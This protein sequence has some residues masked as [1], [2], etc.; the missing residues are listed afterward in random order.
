MG[1]SYTYTDTHKYPKKYPI[2]LGSQRLAEDIFEDLYPKIWGLMNSNKYFRK[3]KRHGVLYAKESAQHTFC[4]YLG[5][6]VG[7][8]DFFFGSHLR[9][10]IATS[11]L[12]KYLYNEGPIKHY[13]ISNYRITPYIFVR[14]R[15]SSP[16]NGRNSW[17]EQ[18][19]YPV[20]QTMGFRNRESEVD[21][22]SH[23][24]MPR[25]NSLVEH[26]I[27]VAPFYHRGKIL[28]FSVAIRGEK[29]Y[30][31]LNVD[32]FDIK[33]YYFLKYAREIRYLMCS[34]GTSSEGKRVL[35]GY[36]K[37]VVS[38]ERDKLTLAEVSKLWEP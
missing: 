15:G 3:S 27:H 10:L 20:Q 37:F 29:S 25:P 18:G 21:E 17:W 1:I 30:F 24:C 9:H 19:V 26:G 32:R 16:R 33:M 23:F 12:G 2:T 36:I 8:R 28:S 5:E 38:G 7:N 13:G 14:T 4:I 31:P 6:D 22:L 34:A 35:D 11:R